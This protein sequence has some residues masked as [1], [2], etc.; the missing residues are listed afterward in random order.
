MRLLDAEFPAYRRLLPDCHSSVAE[1]DVSDLVQAVKR[2]S[3]IADRAPQVRLQFEAGTLTVS[4][5]D[6]GNASSETLACTL[7]GDPLTIAFNPGYLLDGLATIESDTVMVG[8]TQ[9]SRPA[10]L[11]PSGTWSGD[12]G[13]PVYADQVYLIMPVRMPS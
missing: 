8:M 10:V 4:S 5:G 2:A 9:S 7:E 6:D 13:S 12:V 11:A 3:L 1:V